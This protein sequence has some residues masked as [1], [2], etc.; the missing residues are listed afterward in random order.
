MEVFWIALIVIVVGLLVRRQSDGGSGRSRRSAVEVV[1]RRYAAGE[2]ST[3]E[4]EER[5]AG[6]PDA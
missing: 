1:E 4:F 5:G 2:I 6:S 3:E